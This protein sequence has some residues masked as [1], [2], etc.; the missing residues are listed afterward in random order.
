MR[1]FAVGDIHGSHRA[2]L[3]V[4]ELAAFDYEEDQLISLGDVS[5]GWPETAECVEEL[6]RIK[7]LVAIRGNH[8]WWTRKYLKKGE[9][10]DRWYLNGGDS[11]IKSYECFKKKDLK[12]HR[13]FFKKQVNYYIGDK[14]RLYVHGGYNVSI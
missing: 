8:D 12:R 2:L 9:V 10:P 3:Q 13:S 6:L 5:D 14:Q 11:T 1:T 4:L 7:N